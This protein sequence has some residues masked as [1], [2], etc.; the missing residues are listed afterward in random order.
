MK[1]KEL[2]KELKLIEKEL[3]QLYD[4][5]IVVCI[6]LERDDQEYIDT[7][8]LTIEDSFSDEILVDCCC[9]VDATESMDTILYSLITN[10]YENYINPLTK[11]I[12]S[13]K[14]YN[15]RKI[16]SL[17]LWSERGRRDK[18]GTLVNELIERHIATEQCKA[19]LRDPK[20]LIRNLYQIKSRYNT[21]SEAI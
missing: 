21:E 20:E 1:R 4:E 12:R 5:D 19:D 13:T 3:K 9:E 10:I 11:F 7:I 2:E 8:S 17:A 15:A 14:S 18:L 16:K 6:E